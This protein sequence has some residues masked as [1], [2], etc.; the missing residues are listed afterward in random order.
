MNIFGEGD[1]RSSG[2]DS[3]LFGGSLFDDRP[4]GITVGTPL[5]N[6]LQRANVADTEGGNIANEIAKAINNRS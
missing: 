6:T 3:G 5:D 4:S 1:N 2:S